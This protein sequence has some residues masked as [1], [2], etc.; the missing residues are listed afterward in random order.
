MT[1]LDKLLTNW[2][3]AT[4]KL[5]YGVQHTFHDVLTLVSEEKKQNLVWGQDY[6]ADYAKDCLVN[7]SAPMLQSGGGKGIPS[8]NFGEVVGL[9]DQINRELK[10]RD[11]NTSDLVS[12]MAAEI[13]LHHFAP[14]KE[15]PDVMPDT[16]TEAFASNVPYIEPSDDELS[17]AFMEMLTSDAPV[18]QTT[19]PFDHEHSSVQD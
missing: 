5:P 3:L 9:Y 7:A 15:I 2:N 17:R 16:P 6:S 13:L 10:D 11:V 14:L 1:D 4:A 19:T 18:E 8:R 12:P